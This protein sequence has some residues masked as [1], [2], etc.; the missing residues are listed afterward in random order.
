[1]LAMRHPG[2]RNVM[3]LLELS[4]RQPV[5]TAV[6]E[7]SEFKSELVVFPHAGHGCN[8]DYHPSSTE[9]AKAA[10]SPMLDWSKPFGD[11]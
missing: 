6:P 11:A 9:G 4:P 8:G 3:P 1:M 7:I 5:I 10:S 2:V